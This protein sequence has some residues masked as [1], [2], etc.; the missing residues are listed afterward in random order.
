MDLAIAVDSSTAADWAK[1]KT[2]L[3]A[4]AASLPIG[5]RPTD[6]S[7]SLTSFAKYSRIHQSLDET[8]GVM[9]SIDNWQASTEGF[10]NISGALLETR[11][12]VFDP[13]KGDRDDAQNVVLILTGADSDID[14]AADGEQA[15][16]TQARNIK[17]FAVGV[18]GTSDGQ[19]N[20]IAQDPAA[21]HKLKFTTYDELVA[22][23]NDVRDM[24]CIQLG[25]QKLR[26]QE[27]LIAAN[28]GPETEKD[29]KA[30]CKC[31]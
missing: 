27:A 6:V 20:A 2:F 16:R 28:K 22:G 24:M 26:L 10:R 7:I 21:D 4:L 17:T 11:E 13:R 3:I 23:V 14:S 5:T 18:S 15:A 25:K 30:E 9:G 19:L 1:T 31:K 12:Y 29:I 8:A